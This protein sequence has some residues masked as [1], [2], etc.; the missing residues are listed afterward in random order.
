M[1][2]RLN[3]NKVFQWCFLYQMLNTYVKKS[4]HFTYSFY[5][6]LLHWA[7]DTSLATINNLDIIYVALMLELYQIPI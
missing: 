1:G 2:F 6:G 3:D 4:D 5:T 7:V